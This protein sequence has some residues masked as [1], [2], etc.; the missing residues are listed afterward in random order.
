[1]IDT[2]LLT[3]L[4]SEEGESIAFSNDDDYQQKQGSI[5]FNQGQIVKQ[6]TGTFVNSRQVAQDQN[7]SAGSRRSR[8]IR[9]KSRESNVVQSPSNAINNKILQ[10]L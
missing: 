8:T 2:N 3:P 6:T 1:M 10:I 4:E 5:S 9:S 7:A